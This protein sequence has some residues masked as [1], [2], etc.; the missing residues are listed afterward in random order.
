MDPRFA[1]SPADR[2]L[3]AVH[4]GVARLRRCP[5]LLCENRGS[6]KGND[7]FAREPIRT[8]PARVAAANTASCATVAESVISPAPADRQPV[9][10]DAHARV[11]TI[12]TQNPEI[13]P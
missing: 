5:E 11:F 7:L 1:L 2:R 3:E 13:P 9:V 12:D 6:S 8:S 10:A 4:A